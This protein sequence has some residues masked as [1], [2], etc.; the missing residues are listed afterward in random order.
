MDDREYEELL[1]RMIRATINIRFS[2]FSQL[3]SESTKGE[4]FVLGYVSHQPAVQPG[5][6]SQAMQASTAYVAK[7]LR[8]M[9]EKGWIVRRRDPE[10]RRRVLLAL[11]DEGKA[12]ADKMER[13]FHDGIIWFFKKLGDEDAVNFVRIIDKIAEMMPPGGR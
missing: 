6:L 13:Q 9:E 8:G 12:Q 2:D 11:T 1:Q 3:V 7:L 10:D 4:G 5:D